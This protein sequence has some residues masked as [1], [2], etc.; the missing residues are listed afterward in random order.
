VLEVEGK[1]ATFVRVPLDVPAVFG[2]KRAPVKGTING[3][4]FRST[5]AVYGGRFYLPVNRAVREGAGAAAGETVTVELERDDDPRKV[6]VPDDLAAALKRAPDA[7]E[8]FD[9]LSYT[10]Q[11]EYVSWITEAKRDATRQSRVEKTISMLGAGE[12]HP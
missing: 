1:T 8:K 10:H 9:R 11:K 4:P 7:K 2:T 3:H 12:K 5:I 6:D